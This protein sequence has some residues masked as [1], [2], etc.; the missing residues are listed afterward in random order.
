MVGTLPDQ[1]LHTHRHIEEGAY[2]SFSSSMSA[3]GSLRPRCH[4]CFCCPLQLPHHLMEN[5]PVRPL[6][7]GKAM[8][9]LLDSPCPLQ[10]LLQPK[11]SLQVWPWALQLQLVNRPNA[12]WCTNP[13]I[14]VQCLPSHVHEVSLQGSHGTS[15]NH[16]WIRCCCKPLPRDAPGRLQISKLGHRPCFDKLVHGFELPFHYGVLWVL[17]LLILVKDN[18]NT[19]SFL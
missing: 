1:M 9:Q 18:V 17:Q 16:P 12:R 2:L 4:S 7:H 19:A 11:L 3:Q 6:H 5:R 15:N 13:I 10:A 14:Q 8:F